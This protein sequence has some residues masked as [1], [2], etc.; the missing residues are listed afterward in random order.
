MLTDFDLSKQTKNASEAGIV[1]G[2][3]SI[4]ARVIIFFFLRK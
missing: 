1:K 2:K 4:F 3:G